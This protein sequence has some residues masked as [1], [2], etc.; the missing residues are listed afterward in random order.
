MR[1]A[2]AALTLGALVWT[3]LAQADTY[4][5][6]EMEAARLTPKGMSEDGRPYTVTRE[7]GGLR[8]KV[9]YDASAGSKVLVLGTRA[10][11]ATAPKDRAEMRIYSGVT[12]DRT[13]FLGMRA[14]YSGTVEQDAWHLFAQCHQAGSG[15]SPPL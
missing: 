7:G 11:P 3:G 4:Y 14:K 10:T 1:R 9:V 15:K 13:L 6:L 8:P 5:A 2:F 12:F